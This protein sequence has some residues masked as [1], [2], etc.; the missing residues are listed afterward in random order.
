MKKISNK[1]KRREEKRR[2]EKRREEKRREEKRREEKRREERRVLPGNSMTG[3]SP[4]GP[5]NSGCCGQLP[6]VPLGS[7]STKVKQS[8][9]E[10]IQIMN[11]VS[12]KHGQACSLQGLNGAVGHT[13]TE[14]VT[15]GAERHLEMKYAGGCR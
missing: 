1:E 2:E 12:A 5:A 14:L 4:K 15:V 7:T 13:V 3:L 9:M 11:Y 8:W 10:N 6:S